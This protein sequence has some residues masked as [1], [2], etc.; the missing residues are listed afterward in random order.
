[1]RGV[2]QNGC[3]Q[4]G[5]G[6]RRSR[7]TPCAPLTLKLE[8]ETTPDH[9]C[10]QTSL[11]HHAS[12]VGNASNGDPTSRPDLT[13][14]RYGATLFG[15]MLVTQSLLVFQ[16][17][18]LPLIITVQLQLLVFCIMRFT[19]GKRERANVRPSRKCHPLRCISDLRR[20]S[21]R[22]TW[23]LKAVLPHEPTKP[24]KPRLPWRKNDALCSASLSDQSCSRCFETEPLPWIRIS[25]YAWSTRTLQLEASGRQRTL[26]F[27]DGLFVAYKQSHSFERP[28]YV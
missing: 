14:S 7:G 28:G 18:K 27:K 21:C 9:R 25:G 15:C 19:C 5:S 12:K 4:Q 1:M 20:G 8:N 26:G 10:Q 11:D 23:P 16:E 13:A 22:Q 17:W 2:R 24:R 6:S 3:L